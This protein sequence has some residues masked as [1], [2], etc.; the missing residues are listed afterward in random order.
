MRPL[1]AF[2]TSNT[3]QQIKPPSI[4]A[5]QVIAAA[6]Q[7]MIEEAIVFHR[8]GRYREAAQIYGQI[9]KINPRHADSLHLLGMVAS[10]AGMVDLAFNLIGKAIEIDGKVAAYHSN[11]GSIL[12]G[13][14]KLNEAAVQYAQALTLNPRMAEIHLNLGLVLQTQGK[15]AEAVAEYLRA[16]ELNPDLAEAHSNLGNGLQEQLK[17]DDAVTHYERALALKPD[18]PEACYNLGNALQA[19]EKL[20]EA[21]AQFERALALRPTLAEAHG[22]LGNVLQAMGDFDEAQVH[23][24]RAIQLKP[25]FAEVYYNLGNLLSTQKKFDEAVS[26]FQNAL[27]Y[28]PACAK[29]H[30]NLGNVFRS[31]D[32]PAEAV[33]QYEQ[34]PDN[35]PEFTDAYNNLGLALLSLGRHEEAIRSIRRTLAL[36][37]HLAQGYC[38]LGAVYH[39]QNRIAEATENYERALS[40]NPELAKARLN[41]G[42]VQL[43]S[44]DFAAGWKNYEL[45][46]ED[47]PLQRRPFTQPQWR[48]EPLNGA[49][50]LLHAEQGYGDTLQFLRYVPLVLAAGGSVILEVQSRLRRIAAELPGV[51]EVV[52]TGDPLH[53]FDWHCPLLSLPLAFHTDLETIP[54]QTPYLFIPQEAQRKMGALDWPSKGLRVGLVWAGNPTFAQDRYRFRSVPLPLFQPIFEFPGMHLFSLQVGDATVQLA[55]APGAIVD[56]S[57]Q[58]VDMADT[59]A[60]I[61]HLDLVISVDTSVA[62]LAAGLGVPTWVP[63]PYSPDWRWL[64]ERE[65]TPWYPTMRLLRQQRPGDWESVIDR[66]SSAMATIPA[67]PPH[68][69]IG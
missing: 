65:D 60:L 19:Q 25:N 1:S 68:S 4:S 53:A 32:R 30:N 18:F 63:M 34:V 46:W 52:C 27:R 15:L 67:N 6:V 13:Q 64:Q 14:G 33:A 36:K 51:A 20:P 28:D 43:L 16:V 59:A 66:M 17:F 11:L 42:M 35:D 58:T 62:H 23:Y 9:L 37:P 21:A 3:A 2:P 41:L 31:L 69:Q 40:L 5:E 57:P 38:N 8:A 50:I 7:G 26:Q 39:A 61:A 29:A 44:G 22:N 47:A 45:R 10:Q 49:R 12:Q 24:E 48:G 56:L 55:E 54:A